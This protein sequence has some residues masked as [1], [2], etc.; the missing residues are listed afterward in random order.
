MVTK[1]S[2]FAFHSLCLILIQDYYQ[3]QFAMR[4]D[5]QWRLPL[6]LTLSLLN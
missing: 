2:N 3:V 5:H 6:A 4:R 1:R